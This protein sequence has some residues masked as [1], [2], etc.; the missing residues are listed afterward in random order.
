[1]VY[2]RVKNWSEFQH[3]KDRHP[4]WIKLHRAL[5][6]DYEF[7]RLQNASKAHL[8]LIWL[9][10]SQR[11]GR[12]PNDPAFLKKKLGLKSEPNL[13]S[14]VD[15]GLLIP[16][17][18]DSSALADCKQVAPRGED[19]KLQSREPE[20]RLNGHKKKTATPTPESFEVTEQLWAWATEHG[21]A[22]DRV[23]AETE[24]FLN[25]HKAKDSKFSDWN[26]AWRNWMLK[27]VDFAAER[28]T[29]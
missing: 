4:P 3:Y 5:L 18:D 11:D 26:A 2:L 23:E 25:H 10:A 8:M 27:A 16:E 29:H 19:I 7:E 1:V 9:F 6:D 12:I 20:P 24:K 28:R 17:Q 13:K 14:F 22:N 15:Q 21:V